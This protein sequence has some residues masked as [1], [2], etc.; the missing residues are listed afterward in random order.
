MPNSNIKNNVE[1]VRAFTRFY[2]KK[3][4]VLNEL[5]LESNFGLTEAR[6]LYELQTK[7]Q[8]TAKNLGQ[9]LDLD[10]AYISRVLKKFE[11]S[12]LIA[13]KPS[14]LDRRKQVIFLSDQGKREY[15][16][17]DDK[18]TQLFHDLISELDTENQGKLLS[19]MNEIRSLLEDDKSSSSS[20]LLRP[21]R[22]GDMGWIIQAHGRTYAEEYGWDETFE[23]MVAKIAAAFI[24]NFDVKSDCCWIA[25][26]SGQA[27][28]SA[29]VVR[30]DRETAKLRLVIVDPK[31][32]GLGVGVRLVEECINFSRRA[33][34]LKM[35]LWTN[36][37]LY[38]AIAV[39]KKL[40]FKL[41]RQKPHHSFGK[42]L[43][44]QIW[45]LDF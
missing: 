12:G 18:S 25:E 36:D 7:D 21:H 3:A 22:P 13:R 31:A 45:Q 19:A 8:T 44:G 16:V 35:I 14:S 9:E 42:D 20:Y 34:Y 4:G 10:P 17:L 11:K 15:K 1:A 24:E 32:R 38:A 33:G 39:Y 29:V 5:L 37:N 27:I 30:E 40:G 23:A 28:G 41:I 26:K 43:V 2:T 6:I